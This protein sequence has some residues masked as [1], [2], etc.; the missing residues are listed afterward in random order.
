MV[1]GTFQL[2]PSIKHWTI[3]IGFFCTRNGK[4]CEFRDKMCVC[5]L[6]QLF[7]TLWSNGLWPP[8]FLC[9]WDFPGKNTRVGCPVFLQGGQP[10]SLESPWGRKSWT[11]LSTSTTTKYISSLG[12]RTCVWRYIHLQSL[13]LQFRRDMLWQWGHCPKICSCPN[14]LLQSPMRKAV[15]M[16]PLL[17]PD[18]NEIP[19]NVGIRPYSNELEELL[20]RSLIRCNSLPWCC[21]CKWKWKTPKTDTIH[22]V[23]HS[24]PISGFTLPC[25]VLRNGTYSITTGCEW[26]IV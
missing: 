21:N 6:T 9:P 18:P 10:G 19:T 4:N 23:V 1:V 17:N 15:Q 25:H 20:W 5:V 13:L 26:Q 7:P 3:W 12:L 24:F 11:W 14:P 22:M 2:T 8:R 16:T